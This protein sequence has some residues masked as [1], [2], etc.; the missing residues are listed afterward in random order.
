MEPVA[1]ALTLLLAPVAYELEC[2]MGRAIYT[3]VHVRPRKEGY[4]IEFFEFPGTGPLDLRAQI[5]TPWERNPEKLQVH[6]TS[7]YIKEY[8]GDFRVFALTR[9]MT[10]T[11]LAS[12]R[13][14]A[15]PYLFVPELSATIAAETNLKEYPG[16]TLWELT[17]CR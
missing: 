11:F 5:V 4:R 17:A 9:E 16:E 12:Y 1:F 2:P 10:T 8:I 13:N 15:P 6:A 7:G 14:P 3:P